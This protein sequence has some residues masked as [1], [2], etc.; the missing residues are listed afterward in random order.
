MLTFVTT[1]MKPINNELL[2]Q[3]LAEMVYE[4]ISTRAQ[5]F[6]GCIVKFEKKKV[7]MDTNELIMEYFRFAILLSLPS[8]LTPFTLHTWLS[9]HWFSPNGQ[10]NC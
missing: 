5:L 3:N 9:F 10:Q 1:Q 7:R 8:P 4:I 2:A 6:Q